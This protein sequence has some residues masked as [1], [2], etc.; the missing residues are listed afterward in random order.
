M[1]LLD[2][3]FGNTKTEKTTAH[4]RPADASNNEKREENVQAKR[5]IVFERPS[6]KV[7]NTAEIEKAITIKNEFEPYT[8]TFYCSIRKAKIFCHSILIDKLGDLTKFIISSLYTGHSVQEIADLTQMGS[9]TIREELDYLVRGGLVEEENNSLTELGKQYGRLI[10]RF[11]TLSDG[12]DVD[13]NTFSNLFENKAKE[14]NHDNN[15]IDKDLVLTNN[16]IPALARNDNYA[17]SLKIAI[18]HIEEDMPFCR[19]LK[20]SLYT[21]VRIDKST[22]RYKK[23]YLK[24]FRRGMKTPSAS[25]PC[26]EIAIPYMR[27]AFSPMY[28]W[29]DPFR[30][31][32][33]MVR[34]ISNKSPD[35]LSDR[36]KLVASASNEEENANGLLIDI[37][38]ITGDVGHIQDGIS[39]MNL[40]K[41]T[42]MFIPVGQPFKLALNSESCSGLYLRTNTEEKLFQIRFFPYS[43]MEAE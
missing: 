18:E 27:M 2:L 16:F 10:E 40:P 32:A 5:R 21:S 43:R 41:V 13:F 15:E 30:D 22:S 39:E 4:S 33:D 7:T 12:I 8:M 9:L 6:L 3:L 37:N 20:S 29:M 28:R 26:V 38:T 1:G 31:I 34:Q 14:Y 23:I 35:L 24:D 42:E 19:E 25:E 17:N 36:G 11:A